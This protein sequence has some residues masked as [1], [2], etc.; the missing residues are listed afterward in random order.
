MIEINF[1]GLLYVDEANNQNPNLRR[2]ANPIDV[3]ISCAALCARSFRTAGIDFRLITNDAAHVTE[4]LAA[5]GLD[6]VPVVA[7][8]FTW[9]VPKNIS[10]YSA[11]FKLDIIKGFGRRIFGDQIGLVDLDA[12]LLKRLPLSNNLAVYDISD[13]AFATYERGQVL[14][15][16]QRISGRH[17]PEARWY[18]GEFIMGSA[19][20][21]YEISRYVESCWPNYVRYIPT[22][23]HVGDEMIMSVALN[24]ARADG[25]QMVDYGKTGVVARWWTARTQHKQATFQS[26]KDVALLHLPADK[27]FLGR[28]ARY[29]FQRESFLS[30]FRRHAQ[31]KIA[32]RTVYGIGKTLF[33]GSKRFTP[34]LRG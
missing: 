28:Q 33:G 17:L 19:A 3:Y 29:R 26:C 1:Y 25:V 32:L 2:A 8:T 22:L 15:D 21:F 12:V 10:F 11:H 13:E 34:S 5:L 4:R 14:A 30:R 9:P 18:G 20:G 31:R 6:D 16:M 7:Y 27:V 24:M 23:R